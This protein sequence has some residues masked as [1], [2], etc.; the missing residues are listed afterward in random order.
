MVAP[1]KNPCT[2]ACQYILDQD[3]YISNNVPEAKKGLHRPERET[4]TT[5]NQ[6]GL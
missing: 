4:L 2:K 3:I 6:I 5:F 1:E